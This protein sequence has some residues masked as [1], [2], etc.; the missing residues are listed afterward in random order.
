V[1]QPLTPAQVEKLLAAAG[2]GSLVHLVGAGGCGMNGLG[3]LL[4]DRGHRVTGS[5]LVL[6]EETRQL[7]ARG[8]DI[9]RGHSAALIQA[10]R[11]V[12]VAFTS[13]VRANNPE[14]EAARAL[15]IPVVRRATLLAALARC[16]RSIC[17][18]GMHGKTTTTAL[19]A[20]VLDTLGARPSYAVGAL[21]P[22]LPRP[23]C[24]AEGPTQP[25]PWF[26]LEA[27]ESDGTL[28][29]FHPEH[30]ILLNIDAE[31]LDHFEGL[32]S[33]CAEFESFAAQTAGLKVHCRDDANLTR[34]LSG[35]PGAVSYG[36]HPQ[37]DYRIELQA[38]PRVASGGVGAE[39]VFAVWHDGRKLGDFST[40]LL[41]EKNVSNAAAVVALLHQLGYAPPEV[42]RALARFRGAARR[43]ELLRDDGHVRVY[44]DYGHH[45]SEVRATL[46]AFKALRP[47]RLVV[48]FQPHRF[49]RTQHL[50]AEFATAFAEA[51]E[52]FL[53]EIYAASEPPIA[54]VSSAAL[55]QAIRAHGQSVQYVPRLADLGPAVAKAAQPG[56]LILF[57]GAGDITKVAH[58]V[59]A[60]L[61]VPASGGEGQGIPQRTE[62]SHTEPPDAGTTNTQTQRGAPSPSSPR[63]HI[64]RE[65]G[66]AGCTTLHLDCG[67]K[68]RAPAETE[69]NR[70]SS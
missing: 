49:T 18:A 66:P 7:E 28:R 4:L 12:L 11:P 62:S 13:A 33:V 61:A 55:A 21:V 8:A 68:G 6:G 15:R 46:R 48:A 31:H 9:R 41:G 65:A 17:V 25:P 53:T 3:H 44:D 30:T 2:S 63:L 67:A 58:A 52:L 51:D 29:E 24:F 23:A 16:Q 36:F 1:S 14:L 70:A 32:D 10:T 57:L 20:F 39:Q 22:Q 40:P 69:A 19:L 35:R 38:R 5:D 42:G 50:L 64:Q 45:P 59:A 34:L 56:D 27:D 43:Q 26:V 54:G 60:Q 47:G 37:A